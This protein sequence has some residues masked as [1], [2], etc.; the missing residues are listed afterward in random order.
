MSDSSDV[1]VKLL[2]VL[3]LQSFESWKDIC[4][5]PKM[6]HFGILLMAHSAL[7]FIKSGRNEYVVLYHFQSFHT[8]SGRKPFHT[9][10]GRRAKRPGLVTHLQAI[11]MPTFGTHIWTVTKKNDP[12]KNFPVRSKLLEYQSPQKIFSYEEKRVIWAWRIDAGVNKTQSNTNIILITCWFCDSVIKK[13][14]LSKVVWNS[15]SQNWQK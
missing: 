12:V 8:T 13:L 4:L 11:D 14:F 6:A 10:S 1:G 2:L 15:F 3:E 7:N 9:T 5:V